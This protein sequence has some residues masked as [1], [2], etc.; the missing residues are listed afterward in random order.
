M[1]RP[2]RRSGNLPAEATSFV[3]RRRELAEVRRKLTEARLVSLVGPGGVGK[4]RLAVRAAADLGRGFQA[5]AWL[6]E[7]ADVRDPGAVAYAALAALDLRAQAAAEPLA[8]LLA[9]LRDRELLLVVDNC[10]HLLTATAVLL[11]EVL[12]A[13]PGV[14]VIATTREPLSAAGEHLVVVAPLELPAADPAEP[15]ASLARNEAV[16]LFTER[17]AAASGSFRLTDANRSAVVD[18]CRRLDGLPLAIELA[19][20]RTRVLGLEQIRD[21]L[22]DRLGLLTGGVRA[23]LPRHQ[24]LRTT[25][26]WSHDLLVEAERVLLR[27]LCVFAGRFDLDDVESVCAF[28]GVVRARALDVLSSL[29]DKSLVIKEEAAGRAVYRL[30]E[31]MR[32]FAGL[33]LRAAG[34]EPALERRFD[35]HYAAWCLRSGAQGR[36]R[37]VEWL[38]WMDLEVDNVRLVLRRSLARDPGRGLVLAAALGWYWMTRATTEGV[39]W[40]DDLTAAAGAA[41]DHAPARFVRGFLAVLQSDP[42]TAGPALASAAAAFRGPGRERLL[43]ES[44]AMGSIAASLGGDRAAAARLLAEAGAAAAALDDRLAALAVLQA[45]AMNALAAGD[46]AAAAAAATEGERLGRE[47]GDLYTREVML[48]NLGSAALFAGDLP[49]ARPPL[50]E[51][52]R[53]ARRIDDRVAQFYLLDALGCRAA[54]SGQPALGARLMGA[55][56]SVG[57]SAGANRMAFAAPLRERA[58]ERAIVVLGAA[59]FERERS[60]GTRLARDAAAAL[61]LGE[62]AAAAPAGPAA[63]DAGPLARREADVARLVADGLSNRQIGA[64]LLISERT[65]DSHVRSIMNKLGVQSRAQIAAWVAGLAGT[66]EAARGAASSP[67]TPRSGRPAPAERPGRSGS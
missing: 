3:G 65:V 25:I 17:A 26:E 46:V 40:L 51:S 32:E 4:T 49:G 53:I 16:A 48:I 63:E 31:T 66:T 29:V 45:R 64:R 2:R 59:R 55:A 60:A 35:D 37:I 8:V 22:A 24:T 33:E 18:L 61:A 43:A 50:E 20:V 14:R 58:V 15:L 12:E 6:V 54:L 19:A 11:T 36:V 44:L 39:R 7:L 28:D 30:H 10:E 42:A 62:P 57:A 67:L 47:S 23:A 41:A 1:S 52:L 38:E 13:A 34:E 9:H 56:E 27:R 21:R 5:G